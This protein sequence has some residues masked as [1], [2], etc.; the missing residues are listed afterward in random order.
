MNCPN[1]K[2]QLH[3]GCQRKVASDG[4]NVCSNCLATYE[5]QLAANKAKQA[6]QTQ[7][8]NTTPTS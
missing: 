7:V 3:C 6:Q 1:C 2:S 8:N 5:Q 4:T